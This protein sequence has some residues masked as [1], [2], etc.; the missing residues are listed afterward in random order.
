MEKEREGGRGKETEFCS[1][2]SERE[3][4]KLFSHKSAKVAT[5]KENDGR[6]ARRRPADGGD[7]RLAN[8]ELGVAHTA[9]MRLTFATLCVNRRK[10]HIQP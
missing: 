7:L 9:G 8:R 10:A 4:A 6:H 2:C 3:K 5:A 1:Q